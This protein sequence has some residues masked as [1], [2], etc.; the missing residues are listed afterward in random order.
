M[1]TFLWIYGPT[2]RV[3]K[4]QNWKFQP[5]KARKMKLGEI[6]T[7]QLIP[8]SS[9]FL[10]RYYRQTIYLFACNHSSLQEAISRY[11]LRYYIFEL[12]LFKQNNQ[13]KLCTKIQSVILLHNVQFKLT[14]KRNTC[15]Q[16]TTIYFLIF[17]MIINI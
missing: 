3:L 15:I 14:R 11:P 13:K 4:K 7:I 2:I 10:Y 12:I 16:M 5:E 6:S 9:L 1:L 8:S 17:F